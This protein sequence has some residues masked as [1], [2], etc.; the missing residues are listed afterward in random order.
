[1]TRISLFALA[2]CAASP[3]SA[4]FNDLADL[5]VIPG[6]VT[7]NGTHIAGLR[8]DLAPGWKTYWRA[9]GEG[10]IPPMVDFGGSINVNT[11]QFHW[12]VPEVF[13]QNGMRSIGYS[14]GVVLPI[15]LGPKETGPMHLTGTLQIGVCE[16]VCV[17][18]TLSFDT[19]L[20]ADSGRDASL[21][22]ALLDRPLTAQEAGVTA[23]TCE[24]APISDGLQVTASVTLPHTGGREEMVIEAGDAQVWVSEA[25]A[26]RNGDQLV[27]M[28]DMVHGS[29]SAFALDRSAVRITI[30]GQDVAVDV[31]GCSGP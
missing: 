7:Q 18:V 21:L 3:A 1:M 20:P 8:I 16:E 5:S 11:A 2:L 6:W 28:V 30:L 24:V 9:P 27:A 31:I 4:D 15:E 22:A 19:A 13:D 14:S 29:G 23:A 12:P 26:Q 17:P 25:Y 10:G